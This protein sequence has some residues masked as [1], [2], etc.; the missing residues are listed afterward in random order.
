MRTMPILATT[1]LLASPIIASAA[2]AEEH[3]AHRQHEWR[4]QHLRHERHEYRRW[5]REPDRVRIERPEVYYA[6]PPVY[7]EPAPT[8]FGIGIGGDEEDDE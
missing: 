6:P 1:L 2:H 3:D 5:G 8:F 7:Y 4:E